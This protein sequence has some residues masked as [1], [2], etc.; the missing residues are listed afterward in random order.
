MPESLITSIQPHYQVSQ[1]ADMPDFFAYALRVAGPLLAL[2]VNSPFFPPELYEGGVDDAV[3]VEETPMENR[4]KVFESMLNPPENP[5]V[6]FPRDL[7]SVEQAIDRIAA[8]RTVVPCLLEDT[9]RYDDRFRHLRHKHGT[10]WRWVRPVFDGAT[11]RTAN[12]RIEFRPLPAQPTVRDV[13]ALEATYAGLLESLYRRAHPLASMDWERAERNFYQAAENGLRGEFHWV[14]ADGAE[15]TDTE[16]L[17][18]ELFDL[19]RD[20]LELRGL[21]ETEI[22]RYVR[23]LAERVEQGVSPA[24][25]KHDRVRAAVDAGVP[26]TEAVWGMQAEYI[27]RQEDTLIEGSFADWL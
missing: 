13:I 7:D 26:L 16:V 18:A 22:D 23:P 9:G 20:G 15:T 5:K 25:W 21:D 12:A 17:F 1:A 3:I 27:D 11:R 2:A 10:Y 24:R 4:V 14:T 8:D 6:A 19:A